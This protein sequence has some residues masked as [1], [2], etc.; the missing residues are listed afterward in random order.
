[1]KSNQANVSP[2]FGVLA[3]AMLTVPWSVT[4]SANEASLQAGDILV[5]GGIHVVSPKSDNGSLVGGALDVDVDSN[6]RPSATLTY[7]LTPAIGVE[8]LV[9]IPFKHDINIDGL[10]K[11]ATTRHLPPTLSLQYHVN[12]LGRVRPYVGAGINFT[13]IFDTSTT[14]ALNGSKLSLDN[15]FGLAAQAGVDIHLNRDWFVNG[16]IRYIDIDSKARLDGTRI[17]TVEI[18]PLVFGVGVGRRF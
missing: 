1:M 12:D 10:G 11:V 2:L 6:W 5:R 15:S 16:E 9:A 7:M 18:D 3:A 8:L 4:A 14:G 17:G 13:L